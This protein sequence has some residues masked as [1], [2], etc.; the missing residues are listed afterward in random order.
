MVPW[1]FPRKGTEHQTGEGVC[2]RPRHGAAEDRDQ[3]GP[4]TLDSSSQLP[5]LEALGGPLLMGLMPGRTPENAASNQEVSFQP[6]SLP[7]HWA[8]Y[9]FSFLLHDLK[10]AFQGAWRGPAA[11]SAS[12]GR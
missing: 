8:R 1:L 6:G 10:G 9:G 7:V 11:V 5:H 4:W 3:T 12:A 2:R